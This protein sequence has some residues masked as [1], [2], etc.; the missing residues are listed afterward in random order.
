MKLIKKL[1]LLCASLSL[2]A[3]VCAMTACEFSLGGGT[4][5]STAPATSSAEASSEATATA[6]AFKFKV[7]NADGTPST[8]VYIQLCIADTCY[9]PVQ[10]DENG[11][12]SYTS[13]AG[14]VVHEIHVLDAEYAPV[15]FEGAAETGATYN[16]A[17]TLENSLG[18]MT[19]NGAKHTT[20]RIIE[21]TTAR[22]GLPAAWKKIEFIFIRQLMQIKDKKVRK[23]F[24]PNSQ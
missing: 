9:A 24:S 6:N 17:S 20:S 4:S 21:A 1:A 10:T 13:P 22:M 23:V 15:E 19:I 8:N 3:G 18:A 7:L 12:V 14:A 16:M 5:S 2:C 11:E